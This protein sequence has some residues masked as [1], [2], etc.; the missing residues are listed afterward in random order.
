MVTA[1]NPTKIYITKQ[2]LSQCWLQQEVE[3]KCL[4]AQHIQ[5]VFLNNPKDYWTKENK[6]NFPFVFFVDYNSNWDY[7][8]QQLTFRRI[9]SESNSDMYLSKDCQIELWVEE[10][11]KIIYR[12]L[13]NIQK[14]IM[15]LAG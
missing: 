6:T 10:V 4:H 2:K 13:E 8:Q 12:A 9:F 15:C 14:K 11:N 7:M 1:L 5:T 3:N